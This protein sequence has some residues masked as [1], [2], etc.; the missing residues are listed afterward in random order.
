[1][2][3]LR[4]GQQASRIV[5]RRRPLACVGISHGI[6]NWHVQDFSMAR[7][8]SLFSSVSMAQSTTL[9]SSVSYVVKPT[10]HNGKLQQRS[11]TSA[12]PACRM[13]T[14]LHGGISSVQS[15]SMSG[16]SSNV[17]TARHRLSKCVSG[18]PAGFSE[19][20][21]I[22]RST[23]SRLSTYE[24]LDRL[25]S[26][27]SSTT[28]APISSTGSSVVRTIRSTACKVPATI[29]PASPLCHAQNARLAF[30]RVLM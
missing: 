30:Q 12:R 29:V 23:T 10:L 19:G 13:N 9:S 7:S 22:Q 24:S 11:I 1:M 15:I 3:D 26:S 20:A 21:S 16:A 28:R 25:L 6:G 8:T 17:S 5:P 14:T 4:C 27:R 2:R 18:W